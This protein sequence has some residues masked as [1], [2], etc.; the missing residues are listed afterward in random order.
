MTTADLERL[1]SRSQGPGYSP[2]EDFSTEVLALAI[3]EDHRPLLTAI[4]QPDWPTTTL[5][6]LGD[7]LRHDSVIPRTQTHIEQLIDVDAGRPDLTVALTDR[8]GNQRA[9][10]IEAKID[11]PL[12]RHRNGLTQLDVYLAHIP[13]QPVPTAL[14]TLAKVAPLDGRV[15]GLTWESLLRAID[16]TPEP[17][18]W[19]LDLAAFLRG[20]WVVAPST[21]IDDPAALAEVYARIN[22]VLRATWQNPPLPLRW[23]AIKDR[24]EKDGMLE[25]SAGPMIWGM[26]PDEQAP[27]WHVSI[28]ENGHPGARVPAATVVEAMRAAG[29]LATWKPIERHRWKRTELFE[30][31]RPV[32]NGEPGD[33]VVAWFTEAFGD[34]RGGEVLE[35]HFAQVREKLRLAAERKA[36]KASAEDHSTERPPGVA[37]VSW[38]GLPQ[39]AATAGLER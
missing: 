10:W 31:T 5:D 32:V 12:T 23:D 35:P 8:S 11:A 9:L 28:A 26:W 39:P 13:L 1:Y 4:G 34:L 36:I 14:V 29:L 18:R 30:K 16:A 25:F 38:T 27:M 19:W 6:V 37:P 17:D 22:D 24:V 20:R 3:R 7:P 33:A 15:A 21:S 2:L